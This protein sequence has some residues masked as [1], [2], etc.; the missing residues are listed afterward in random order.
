MTEPG[1]EERG[2]SPARARAHDDGLRLHQR[3]L[4]QNEPGCRPIALCGSA[5]TPG[6]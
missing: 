4:S 1:E 6:G 5:R 2:H 3:A